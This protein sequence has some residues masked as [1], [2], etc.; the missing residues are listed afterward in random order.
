MDSTKTMVKIG[1]L[2][3]I[4]VLMINC[5]KSQPYETPAFRSVSEKQIAVNLE[6]PSGLSS[7]SYSQFA[8]GSKSSNITV[9]A[10]GP[11][12]FV[13]RDEGRI[14]LTKSVNPM[15]CQIEGTLDNL[16]LSSTSLAEFDIENYFLDFNTSA[17]HG[18]N[19][20]I[21]RP[22]GLTLDN[23]V[24]GDGSVLVS[25]NSSD[26]I[27]KINLSGGIE[28]YLQ[29][30]ELERITDIILGTNG[31]VYAA[32]VCKI[33]SNDSSKVEVSKRVI[34]IDNGIINIEFVLPSDVNTHSWATGSDYYI[35]NWWR[36]AP[37]FEK[38][39]VIE[40]S[41]IG[42]KNFGAEFYVSDLL[43]DVIYKVDSKKNISVL[44][45]GL[46]HPSSLVVDAEGNIFY[47]NSPLWFERGLT[48]IEYPTE[49]RVLNPETGQSTTIHRFDEKNID[50]YTS[51]GTGMY[52]KYNKETYVLP[53]G[54]NVTGILN[55]SD[56]ALTFLFTNS[57][58]GT[59][60]QLLVIK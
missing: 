57:H 60:K 50:E 51:S 8:K 53:I 29:N 2:V 38:L 19:D 10:Q 11:L 42:K 25:S 30:K 24:L 5:E 20:S 36:N 7:N 48:D 28:V 17:S 40:N 18:L 3:V 49:L 37:Y 31:K 12:F 52:V 33:N 21:T 1:I 9:L 47:T 35:K 34:S 58:Q 45:E 56:N 15:I 22:I 39:K 32:A 23:L 59:L 16:G 44:A 13:N 43:E 6:H 54:F 55:E 26:K 14:D 4:Q 27:F 46:R 41:E